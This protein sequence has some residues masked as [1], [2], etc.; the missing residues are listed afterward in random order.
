MA[1]SVNAEVI[2][3][4]AHRVLEP[5]R[6]TRLVDERVEAVTALLAGA[7]LRGGL[8]APHHFVSFVEQL[9]FEGAEHA[10]R[11]ARDQAAHHVRVAE[12]AGDHLA[13]VRR[14]L[15][16]RP[17]A[18]V[19][20]RDES[21]LVLDAAILHV[22]AQF[23]DVMT[24]PCLGDGDVERL[25]DEVSKEV[26]R[27]LLALRPIVGGEQDEL[28]EA[29]VLDDHLRVRMDELGEDRHAHV[30]VPAAA[31]SRVGEVRVERPL[32]DH[33]RRTREAS[34]RRGE[35]LTLV[36]EVDA[37]MPVVLDGGGERTAR[38]MLGLRVFAIVEEL[39]H[40]QGDELPRASFVDDAAREPQRVRPALRLVVEHVVRHGRVVPADEP[41][42]GVRMEE[43]LH[44]GH[45]RREPGVR[46]IG[47]VLSEDL[48]R[49]LPLAPVLVVGGVLDPGLIEHAYEVREVLAG[50]EDSLSLQGETLLSG[51]V[52]G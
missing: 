39:R 42:L 34:A 7:R 26:V 16:L 38:K 2:E 43:R 23:S 31:S 21:L 19:E 46:R 5:G 18:V 40:R 45:D 9:L 51:G 10:R 6:A 28:L 44:H 15:E 3:V 49:A 25:R 47:E 11:V 17:E 14:E 30:L 4:V 35:P 32:S 37:Q 27:E 48:D 52:C 13:D 29:T 41:E 22:R 20:P 8:H 1:F 50:H 33:G 36:V 24:R 12:L